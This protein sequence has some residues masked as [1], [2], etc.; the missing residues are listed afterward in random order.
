M[1]RLSIHRDP[2]GEWAALYVDGRL[3]RV[4]DSYL[5]D[6]R[7]MEILGVEI[8]QD[9]AFLRGQSTREGVAQTLP[10]VAAYQRERAERLARARELRLSA[11][12]AITEAE[13][14]EGRG[15]EL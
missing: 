7:A 6:E 9:N 5:A 13:R 3:D 11:A 15:S 4:G 14:L 8:V 10:E 2:D 1:P 12:E